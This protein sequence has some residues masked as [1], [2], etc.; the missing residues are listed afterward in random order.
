MRDLQHAPPAPWHTEGQAMTARQKRE[1][2]AMQAATV[3]HMAELRLT[4]NEIAA[5]MEL[6]RH[7]VWELLELHQRRR[8]ARR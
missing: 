8:R 7:R 4:L 3:W 6:P 5:G 2:L 1:R